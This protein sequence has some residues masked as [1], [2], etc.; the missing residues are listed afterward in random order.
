MSVCVCVDDIHNNTFICFHIYLSLTFY[1][2]HRSLILT[3][4]SL[5][6]LL[7]QVISLPFH[8]SIILLISK[9]IRSFGPKTAEDTMD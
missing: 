4:H 6:S 8:S 1:F 5:S 3:K 2:C 9:V 7:L